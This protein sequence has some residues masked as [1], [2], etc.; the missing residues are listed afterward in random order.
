MTDSVHTVLKKV[1]HN[2]YTVVAITVIALVS[3]FVFGCAS[4]TPGIVDSGVKVDA[5][6]FNA[7]VLS[8]QAELEAAIAALNARAD[9]GYADLERQDRLRTEALATITGIVEAYVPPPFSN[10]VMPIASLGGLILAGG[11][12]LDNRRK[13]KVIAEIKEA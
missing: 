1:D 3:A 13:N 9:A 5:I 4:T 8:E 11:F 7:Q 10:M 6:E 2:R 12:G